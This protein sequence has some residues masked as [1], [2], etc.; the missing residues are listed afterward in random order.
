MARIGY[1]VVLLIA[2]TTGCAHVDRAQVADSATTAIAISNGFTEANWLFAD[3]SWPWIAATKIAVTQTVKLTPAPVCKPGLMV[4]TV[5]GYNAALWNIGV[6][7]G[8]GPAAIP[9]MALIT[10]FGW[11]PWWEDAQ[12]VCANPFPGWVEK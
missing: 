4:L 11:T 5:F 7:A 6:M 12:Q 9:V 2:L 8:S 10:W 3:M 1:G